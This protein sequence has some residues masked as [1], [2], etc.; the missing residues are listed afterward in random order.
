MLRMDDVWIENIMVNN[1]TSKYEDA[2]F[3]PDCIIC[4]WD[5]DVDT[6]EY[7]VYEYTRIYSGSASTNL[8]VKN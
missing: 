5:E 6:F 3:V 4:I 8:Y 2:D 7:H 1:E